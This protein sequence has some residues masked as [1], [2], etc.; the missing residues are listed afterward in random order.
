MNKAIQIVRVWWLII[1]ANK[2]AKKK[3]LVQFIIKWKGKPEIM[4]YDSLKEYFHPGYL[5]QPKTLEWI[6]SESIYHTKLKK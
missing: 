4:D 2:R 6:K 3:G 5:N 1:V